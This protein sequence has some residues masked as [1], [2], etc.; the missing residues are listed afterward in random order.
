MEGGLF[1]CETFRFRWVVQFDVFTIALS[2]DVYPRN[3]MVPWALVDVD[4]DSSS[5]VSR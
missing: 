4:V 3:A 2:C 1:V 5:S